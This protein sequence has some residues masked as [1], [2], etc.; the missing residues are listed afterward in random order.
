VVALKYNSVVGVWHHKYTS[1]LSCGNVASKYYANGICRK[2]VGKYKN[3]LA[4]GE[5]V[6]KT[7]IGKD[8][9]FSTQNYIISRNN[10]TLSFSCVGGQMVLP[11][12][13]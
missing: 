6:D 3:M 7:A 4:T 9:S 5:V 13:F 11:L 10:N 12:Y 1:C 2:C 8:F